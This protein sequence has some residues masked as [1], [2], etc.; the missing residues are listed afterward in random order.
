MSARHRTGPSTRTYD[1][2]RSKANEKKQALIVECGKCYSSYDLHS[3][4]HCPTCGA[5]EIV[6][7]R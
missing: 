5:I 3:N 2:K 6:G 7:D 1:P 4:K